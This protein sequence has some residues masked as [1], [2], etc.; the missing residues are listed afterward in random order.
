MDTNELTRNQ[1]VTASE[2][3]ALFGVHPGGK[4]PDD[5]LAEKRG[6][7]RPE[8]VGN[9]A[10]ELGRHLEDWLFAKYEAKLGLRPQR[11]ISVV[12]PEWRISA[13]LDAISKT[14]EPVEFK[15]HGLTGK[16]DS[17]WLGEV[18]PLSVYLQVMTQLLVSDAKA[19]IVVALVGGKGIVEWQVLYNQGWA[20]SILAAVGQFLKALDSGGWYEPK[21]AE[22]RQQVILPDNWIEQKKEID[23]KIEE[24]EAQSDALADRIRGALAGAEEAY[25]P[26]GKWCARMQHIT[27]HTADVQKLKQDGLYYKYLRVIEYDRL[28]YA[29]VRSEKKK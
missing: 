1:V 27:Q 26:S 17:A 7:K 19:G 13:T 9:D 2:V 12:K 24:L 22:K 8:F 16:V 18:A 3:P 29:S 15:T 4:T 21:K 10:E 14:G 25:D 23:R 6:L 20:E 11:Q 5:L 28:F